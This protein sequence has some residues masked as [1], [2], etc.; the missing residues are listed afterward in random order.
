MRLS[1]IGIVLDAITLDRSKVLG[2]VRP[3]SCLVV[4]S[5][6]DVSSKG[7]MDPK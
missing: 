1:I 6:S 2:V 5:H 4:P 3:E 7:Y